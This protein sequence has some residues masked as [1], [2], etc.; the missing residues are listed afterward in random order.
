MRIWEG[1]SQ[2][3]AMIMTAAACVSGF[4]ARP[5]GCSP[6][7]FEAVRHRL[8]SSFFEVVPPKGLLPLM[9]YSTGSQSRASLLGH[10]ASGKREQLR[11]VAERDGGHVDFEITTQPQ[12]I[13]NPERGE[14]RCSPSPHS[15]LLGGRACGP[16]LCGGTPSAT[17]PSKTTPQ[18]PFVLIPA[19]RLNQ[20]GGCQPNVQSDR[21]N[22]GEDEGLLKTD[23]V[24]GL[25]VTFLVTPLVQGIG[26]WGCTGLLLHVFH[27]T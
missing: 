2:H 21:L 26:I 24:C 20:H 4:A 19:V 27:D 23:T 1:M 12:S 7:V 16:P 9:K 17:P 11:L 5:G 18:R 14:Q 3:W 8:K 13:R 6:F 10:P 25:V 22:G 15:C